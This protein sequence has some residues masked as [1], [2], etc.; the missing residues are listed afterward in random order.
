MSNNYPFIHYFVE[1]ALKKKSLCELRNKDMNK[2]CHDIN[3]EAVSLIPRLI[4]EVKPFA[5]KSATTLNFYPAKTFSENF[6]EKAEQFIESL[7][8][9]GQIVFEIQGN[10]KEIT[11]SFH[12]EQEDIKIIDA[13]LK[14]Y[15]PQS[16]TELTTD[17]NIED[18]SV[19]YDFVP[20]IDAPFYKSMTSY[21][22]FKISPLNLVPQMFLKIPEGKTGVYQVLLSPINGNIHEIVEECVD[23]EWMGRHGD[24]NKTTPSLQANAIN[25]KLEYKSPEFRSYYAV[26]FRLILPDDSLKNFVNAF[27][28]NYVYGKKSFEIITDYTQEKISAMLNNKAVFHAGF[29][30]NSHETAGILHIPFG[31]MN[32]KAFDDVLQTIPDGDYPY[33]MSREADIEIGKWACGNST[34]PVYLPIQ[35]YNPHVW[36]MG[37]QRSG[38]SLLLRHTALEKFQNGEAV[39][40]IDPHGDL[41][42][43]IIRRVDKKLIPKVVYID[44]GLKDYTPLLTIRENLDVQFIGAGKFS[45]DLSA[46]ME[47][48]SSTRNNSSWYGPKM[49][50]GFACIFYLYASVPEL[51]FADLRQLIS[52]SPRGQAMREKIKAKVKHPVVIN[53]LEEIQHSSY[54][55]MQP[56][57]TRLAHLLLDE[58]SLRFFTIEESKNQISLKNSMETGQLCV[59]NLACGIIGRQR[60]SMLSGLFDSIINNLALQRAHI[61][62]SKR[63]PVTLIK[64]EFYLGPGDLDS[65]LSG[66]SKYQLSVIFAHQYLNQVEGKTRDVMETA[67]TK[68][69]FRLRPEDAE[70]IGKHHKIPPE[71]LIKLKPSNAYVIRDNEK[72]RV[73]TVK[74][75]PSEYDSSQEIKEMNLRKY[76]SKHSD[77]GIAVKKTTEKR[78]FD[79]L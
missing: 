20:D 23:I 67:G 53:F 65:Q 10:C 51:N 2:S 39:F 9:C 17:S 76:Y 55:S 5:W 7:H 29:L 41:A 35:R 4:S 47:T 46:S 14:N 57:L 36:L 3:A 75:S 61:P 79:T 38:K 49:A 12:A 45:D 70:V 42:E 22:G 71:E 18:K 34:L 48:I 77:D 66:L 13:A 24:E 19:V 32:E 68:I 50:Y 8:N 64:D 72:V 44:F 60:S 1:E 11:F 27:I 69:F 15:F 62:F 16:Y 63:R 30:A 25:K 40:V 6:L 52:K 33:I 56:V 59:I 54:D 21:L 37:V 74:Y 78:D 28:A 31:L 43:D 26:S 58:K 73:Q